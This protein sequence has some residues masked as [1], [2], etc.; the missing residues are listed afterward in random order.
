MEK[1]EVGQTVWYHKS[2]RTGLQTG[3]VTKVGRKYI[4]VNGRYKYYIETLRPIESTGSGG[5]LILDLERY[6][7]SVEL[8]ENINKIRQ[9]ITNN[10]FQ[11]AITLEQSIEVLNIL[12]IKP[13]KEEL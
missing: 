10:L 6:N 3:E 4:E 11:A 1:L 12:R 13:H 8:N 7:R 9:F 5:S 2:Y